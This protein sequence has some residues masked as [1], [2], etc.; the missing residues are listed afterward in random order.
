MWKAQTPTARFHSNLSDPQAPAAPMSARG[1][2][3]PEEKGARG[4]LG[5]ARGAGA[6]GLAKRRYERW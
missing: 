4:E 3:R 1:G 6:K 2:A 5:S